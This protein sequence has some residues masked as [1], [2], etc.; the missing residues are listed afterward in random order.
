MIGC[1]EREYKIGKRTG[2]KKGIDGKSVKKS[3]GW[4]SMQAFLRSCSRYSRLIN[5]IIKYSVAL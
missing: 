1:I 5:P 4:S 3:I 2:R